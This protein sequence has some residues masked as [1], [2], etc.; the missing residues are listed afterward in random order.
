[1]QPLCLH[2]KESFLGKRRGQVTVLDRLH[3]IANSFKT[4]FELLVLESSLS[5]R[6]ASKICSLSN[7]CPHYD[8][9]QS[10]CHPS[11]AQSSSRLKVSSKPR[12]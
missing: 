1:M 10:R 3:S 2:Y 8:P 5:A 7:N 9:A 12:R 11:I 4:Y 6:F